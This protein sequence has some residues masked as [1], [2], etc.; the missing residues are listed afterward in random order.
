MQQLLFVYNADAGFFNMVTD[1]AHKI[2]SPATYPCSLCDL[3]YGVL[4]IRPEWEEFVQ[5]AP[6][7]FTF[8]HKDEFLRDYPDLKNTELPVVLFIKAN[9]T[10]ELI[11]AHE[12]NTFQSVKQLSEVILERLN[13]STKIA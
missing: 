4:K 11:S 1:I 8:L 2:F 6:V 10:S 9:D 5:N 12:L 13:S 3:T 7:P